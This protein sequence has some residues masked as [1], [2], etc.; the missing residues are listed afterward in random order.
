MTMKPSF[1]YKC[2][3]CG[4]TASQSEYTS[5]ENWQRFSIGPP[6]LRADLCVS[7]AEKFRVVVDQVIG[8][9]P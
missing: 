9:K 3:R 4:V 2:D 6:L 7:C 1:E 8:G 5:P